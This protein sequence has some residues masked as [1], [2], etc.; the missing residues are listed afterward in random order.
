M[1]EALSH[2]AADGVMPLWLAR[3]YGVPLNLAHRRRVYLALTA[4]SS[5]RVPVDVVAWS[6]EDLALGPRAMRHGLVAAVVRWILEVPP[7]RW[8]SLAVRSKR[9][10]PLGRRWARE[11]VAGGY[12]MPPRPD[13]EWWEGDWYPTAVEVDT[14]KLPLERLRPRWEVWGGVYRRVIWVVLSPH[15]AEVVGGWLAEFLGRWPGYRDKGWG[16]LLLEG[17]GTGEVRYEWVR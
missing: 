11:R 14:G 12:R 3:E 5:R 4:R 2:L 1:V 8:D 9:R 10:T 13:A 15:R 6:R 7:G 16:L 17:W